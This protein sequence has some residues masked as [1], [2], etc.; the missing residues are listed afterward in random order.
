MITVIIITLIIILDVI[1]P[2]HLWDKDH[3]VVIYDPFNILVGFVL[4]HFVED[5]GIYLHERYWSIVFL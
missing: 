4:Y 2:L 5:F 1:P 3:L